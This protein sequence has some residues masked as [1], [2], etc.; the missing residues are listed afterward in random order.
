MEHLGK[1]FYV[2]GLS[3]KRADADVRGQFSL[4][5]LQQEALLEDLKQE[6]VSNALVLST[7]NRVEIYG[8]A[9]HPYVLIKY[10]C[11]HS[12]GALEL[13]ERVSYIS[14]NQDAIRHLFRVGTGLDSQILGD[15]EIIGQIKSAFRRSKGHS[16]VDAFLERLVNT[17]IQASKRIKN[18]TGLSSGAASLA[19]AATHRILRHF[20]DLQ[21]KR[22]L[23]LGTGKIGRNTC[24]NLLKHAPGAA[25]TLINRT[26]EKAEA[27]ARAYPVE[28]KDYSALDK[29]LAQSDVLVVATGASAPTVSAEQLPLDRP[30]LVLDLSMPRNV[31]PQ[32]ASLQNVRLFHIDQLSQ[33]TDQTLAQRASQIPLAE[34]IS[35]CFEEEFLNW[36]QIRKFAPAIAS[37]KARLTQMQAAELDFQSRRIPDFN[38]VQAD[39]I[40]AR[41]IHKITTRYANHLKRSTANSDEVIALFDEVFG[42]E[43]LEEVPC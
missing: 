2:A 31:A 25:V 8:F 18:E 37:F 33:Q 20:D 28:V 27:I 29:T 41:L 38:R 13:F 5:E 43:S 34:E 36:L 19:F 4:T 22:I 14:K 26:R 40:S 42:L 35:I 17:V 11:K 12:K 6:A 24:E 16:L 21:G 10:L 15:F 23:L 32:A 30:L 7:C 1:N 9:A 3:F 39:L